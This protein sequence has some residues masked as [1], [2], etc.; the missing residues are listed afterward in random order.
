[1]VRAQSPHRHPA[2]AGMTASR[3]AA[4]PDGSSRVLFT[5]PQGGGALVFL[6][7]SGEYE[8][9]VPLTPKASFIL[10]IDSRVGLV[11]K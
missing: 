1:M 3:I 4:G 5:D 8:G 2:P 6:S 10:P 11:R 9:L 7:A